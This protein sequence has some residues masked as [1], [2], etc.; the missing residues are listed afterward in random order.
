MAGRLWLCCG[1][2]ADPGAEEG[3]SGKARGG[4]D[5]SGAGEAPSLPGTVRWRPG[6]RLSRHDAV[7]LWGSSRWSG[8]AAVDG[9]SPWVLNA[10][11]AAAAAMPPERM[12]ERLGQAG[13][14]S[15]RAGEEQRLDERTGRGE[16]A[17]GPG[18]LHWIGVFHL[19][20]LWAVRVR[21]GAGLS[22][23]QAASLPDLQDPELRR[24]GRLAWR[25]AYELGLDAGELLVRIADDG[26]MRLE[27]LRLA[28]CRSFRPAGPGGLPPE[29]A[30]LRPPGAERWAEAVER[31]AAAVAAEAERAG[32][33]AR[34]LRIGADP[35]F[36]LLRADGR[37]AS[38]S[39]L[40]GLHSPVGSD[41]LV[42][43]QS[44]RQPVGE[45]RPEPAFEPE[46]LLRRIRRLL[47]LA[48][49]RGAGEPG[50][51]LAAGGMPVPGIAL[52]GHVHLSGLE[53]TTRLL[54]ALDSYAALPLALAEDPCGRGRRPRYGTLGD[55]RRQPHGGFEYRTLPSWLVS[56]AAARYALAVC[57]LAA[58][59]TAWLEEL[60]AAEPSYAQ[61][62]YAGDRERLIGCLPRLRAGLQ[63]A[64]SYAKHAALLEPFL[65][66]VEAGRRWEEKAD[67]RLR[68]GIPIAE[69]RNA[70]RPAIGAE[71]PAHGWQ[72]APNGAAVRPE[73]AEG[74]AGAPANVFERG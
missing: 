25:A 24:A 36:L 44:L 49:R 35:E 61:A 72:A 42:A 15:G 10:G 69:G 17:T 27:G 20:T 18:R 34:P 28:G 71:A 74:A 16:A 4:A 23:M 33:S 2:E 65:D 31:L 8:G 60:P 68:W 30:R 59:D 13:I 53:L 3:M 29:A 63:A 66:A 22:G 37:V 56:P 9:G 54:R 38:A 45:L 73:A 1:D 52:G 12:A 43:G 47:A 26:R 51:R 58:E 19:E 32:G 14:R 7:L 21:S 41:V 6:A 48:S 57:M 40:G 46:E 62:Y 39:R 70:A 5:G 67:I 55:C 64:P 11:A 50:M